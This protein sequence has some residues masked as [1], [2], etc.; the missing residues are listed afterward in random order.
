MRKFL[1]FDHSKKRNNVAS[2]IF[3][4]LPYT[5]VGSAVGQNVIG[6]LAAG[7]SA[8]T[9][10]LLGLSMGSAMMGTRFGTKVAAG[11]IGAKSDDGP[12]SRWINPVMSIGIA[13]FTG[14]QAISGFGKMVDSSMASSYV[15]LGA[16]AIG[17]FAMSRLHR[18]GSS[19]KKGD[20]LV[21]DNDRQV[22]GDEAQPDPQ[23]E[24]PQHNNMFTSP[25]VTKE[26]SV[27]EPSVQEQRKPLD[28][29][30]MISQNI[31]KA[32]PVAET[33]PYEKGIPD[34]DSPSI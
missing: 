3:K 32:E 6:T 11:A 30:S 31:K 19:I 28:I 26:K 20:I 22:N 25:S 34:R 9:P 29:R 21:D 33:S 8:T 23:P 4:V 2:I 10:A 17:I 24:G 15:A 14:I 27:E 16:S 12:G 5:V 1:S 18:M 7:S 13:A